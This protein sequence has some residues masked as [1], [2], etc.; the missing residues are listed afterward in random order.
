MPLLAVTTEAG[1][2]KL[3]SNPFQQP[4]QQAELNGSI[5]SQK[6]GLSRKATASIKLVKADGKGVVIPVFDALV[7]G[8]DVVIASTDGGV[9]VS[10]QKVRWQDDG[11]GELLFDGVREVF[12]LVG[13]GN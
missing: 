3:F 10:F 5:K 1:I 6:K 8:P 13:A 7:Y 11:T 9:D 4:P 12:E 2:V